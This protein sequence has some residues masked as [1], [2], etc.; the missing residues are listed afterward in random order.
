MFEFCEI[1]TIFKDL[2]SEWPSQMT[3]YSNREVYT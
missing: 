3:G 1:E 2:F